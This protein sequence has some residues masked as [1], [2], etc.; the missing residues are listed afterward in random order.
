MEALIVILIIIIISLVFL[1]LKFSKESKPKTEI[2]EIEVYK[3]DD[4]Y[5]AQIKRH[6]EIYATGET[7]YD[8]VGELVNANRKIFKVEYLGEYS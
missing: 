8:A 2:I 1:C 4:G 3:I 5:R 6:T 7:F